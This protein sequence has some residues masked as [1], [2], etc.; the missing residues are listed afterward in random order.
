MPFYDSLQQQTESQRQYLMAAP[1]FSRMFSGDIC[2]ED[3]AAFLAQAYQ[4]VKHTVPLLMAV[5]ARLPDD[6]GWLLKAVAEYIEEEFGHEQWILD[7][8]AAAGFDPDKARLKEPNL[9]TELLVAYAYDTVQRLNPLGFFGMV[10]V[11]EGTSIHMADSAASAIQSALGLP[12]NAFHYLRSH[13][14]LDIEHV[15]LFERLMN[16]INE[17][18]EQALIIHSA[19]VFYRL[20]GDIFRSLAPEQGHAIALECGK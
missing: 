10:Q 8:I 19:Q 17:P 2:R 9:A 15:K 16:Q 14:M 18:H 4:H 11:L 20:Y 13:G 1:I 5:G 7:D 3:Y 12:D 6:K